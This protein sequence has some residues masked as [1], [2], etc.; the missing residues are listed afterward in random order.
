MKITIVGMG[1]VGISNAFLLHHK[2]DILCYDIDFYKITKLQ[3]SEIFKKATINKNIAY[4]DP[5]F[6]FVCG[7][8][9]TG[10][11]GKLDMSIIENILIDIAVH[12]P[13]SIVVI[14]STVSI[15]FTNKMIKKTGLTILFSPEFLREGTHIEDNL[16]PERIIIGCQEDKNIFAFLLS[17][18]VNQCIMGKNVPVYICSTQEAE[19]SKLLVN[20]MLAARVALFNEIDTFC[21]VKN[22][23]SK[24]VIKNI[25]SDSRIGDYYN[26]PSFGFGGYCL[27][28][29][30]KEIEIDA[31][32]NRDFLPLL[33]SITESNNARKDF[34][35]D[36]ILMK[37]GTKRT[38]IYKL[39]MKSGS[40]NSRESAIIDIVKYLKSNG[41][42]LLIY[43][44]NEKENIMDYEVTYNMDY[45]FENIDIIVTNRIDEKLKNFPGE[46]LTPDLFH[47]N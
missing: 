10:I 37:I 17:R 27:P 7:P 44:E 46:I 4:D 11:T 31:G 5:D 14:K 15:G 35:S 16:F 24:K 39:S 26:N 6:I 33:T 19:A 36:E 21:H 47:R 9:D 29:D 43:D 8:T 34:M 40:N 1:Y 23:D 25:C 22:I 12:S 3:N 41:I 20:T 2:N 30:S 18:V 38:G 28:K 42:N 45:F 32:V 13:N